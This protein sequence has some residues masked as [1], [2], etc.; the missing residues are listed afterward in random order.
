MTA[1]IETDMAYLTGEY[2]E[3]GV[4]RL[5]TIVRSRGRGPIALDYLVQ[6]AGAS[7]LAGEIPAVNGLRPGWTTIRIPEASEDNGRPGAC[8][9][10]GV[11]PWRRPAA[12]G[13][14]RPSSDQR[15]RGSRDHGLP[16]D[17]R[18]R[19]RARHRRRRA[20]QPGVPG[21]RGC[22]QPHGGG[23]HRRR[24][25]APGAGPGHGRRPGPARG[26]AEPHAGPH[27]R[28]DGQP[29]PGE[30][31]RGARPAHAAVAL[32][33]APGGRAAAC[34][35]GGGIRGRGRWR[36]ARSGGPAGHLLGPAAHRAGR[37]RLAPRRLR[38]GGPERRG[39]GGRRRLPA[40]MRRRRP[41]FCWP[42]SCPASR[43]TATRNC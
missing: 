13:G 16:V 25:C 11:G 2:R 15:G 29:A 26:H 21:P 28:L 20:A 34:A 6:D 42:A 10:A 14:R 18:A 33:P 27:R 30:H 38:P 17:D 36:A 24:P 35:L 7:H 12:C 22:D 23:D 39:R 4:D 40:R 1:R 41:Q 43:S 19:G 8:A 9:G 3:G 31:G 32:V 37:G 5:L